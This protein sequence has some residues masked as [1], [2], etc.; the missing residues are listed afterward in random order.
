MRYDKSDRVYNV[1]CLFRKSDN[2]HVVETASSSFGLVHQFEIISQE[3]KVACLLTEQR[4]AMKNFV[5][6]QITDIHIM[7]LIAFAIP[8]FVVRIKLSVARV[9]LY[10]CYQFCNDWFMDGFC[11]IECCWCLFR[12]FICSFALT[13]IKLYRRWAHMCNDGE[14]VLTLR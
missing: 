4:F 2:K 8:F 12:L 6:V 9:L 5:Q 13:L 14:N 1:F 7:T 11:R 3:N 10:L